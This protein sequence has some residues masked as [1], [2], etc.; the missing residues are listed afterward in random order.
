MR[1]DAVGSVN[2]PGIPAY[3]RALRD[4]PCTPLQRK[5]AVLMTVFMT[6]NSRPGPHPHQNSPAHALAPGYSE[7]ANHSRSLR[8]AATGVPS[9]YAEVNR[10]HS[11][12]PAAMGV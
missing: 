12:N 6:R 5:N 7:K 10:S 8:L 2:F 3:L 9:Y 1:F 4:F 11:L